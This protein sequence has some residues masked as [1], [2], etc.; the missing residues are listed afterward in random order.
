[1]RA[2]TARRAAAVVLLAALTAACSGDGDSGGQQ[3][4][5]SRSAATKPAKETAVDCSDEDLSQ[6]DWMEHCSGDAAGTGE[7]GSEEQA[8]GL[9][10][11]GSYTWPDGLKVTVV[12]AKVFTDY[13]TELL[14]S[15]R[16]G[17]RDFRVT[18]KLENTGSAPVALDELSLIIEGATNGGQAATTTFEKGSE[19]L[20]GRLA[21]GVAVTKTD[22]NALETKYGRK[23][24]VIVQ[25]ASENFDLE[26]PEFTGQITG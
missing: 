22:D 12:G 8:T 16:P 11:G 21:P 9:R 18:L 17:E 24:V 4:K 6:A 23:V 13:D 25:R 2:R 19:P 10:F 26:F 5:A 3:A 15:A 20:E 14:E 1:M 7:D